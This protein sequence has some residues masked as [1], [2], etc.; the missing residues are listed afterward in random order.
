MKHDTSLHFKTE[1]TTSGQR[2]IIL[3]NPCRKSK[4]K[5]VS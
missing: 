5:K 4:K 3:L 1:M 2:V